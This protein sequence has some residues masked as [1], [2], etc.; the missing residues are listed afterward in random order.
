MSN[1]VSIEYNGKQY[2]V[3]FNLNVIEELQE[4]YGTLDRWGKLT[5][6]AGYED[7]TEEEL[8]EIASGKIKPEPDFK[9]LI[10]GFTAMIN[11][12]IEIQNDERGE[13]NTLFTR[14]QIGRIVSA[15][16]L[17]KISDA[18]D[19]SVEAAADEDEKNV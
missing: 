5:K 1:K 3:V 13:K 2:D 18:M 9:A 10:D 16:G 19:S 6:D 8:K 7:R 15:V 4:K 14:K 12:G 17:D 11:E